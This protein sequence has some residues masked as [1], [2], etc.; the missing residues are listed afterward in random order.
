MHPLIYLPECAST[1]DEITTFLSDKS[2]DFKTLSLYTFHQ[3]QGRGQYGNVWKT[4]A[5]ENLAISIALKTSKIAIS[6]VL[7]NFHTA[8]VVR[9]FIANLTNQPTFVKWPNDIILNNKKISGMLIEKK[10]VNLQEYYIIGIGINVLQTQFENLPKAG[11]I[12]TQASMKLDLKD[13]TKKFHDFFVRSFFEAKNED[14]I[15]QEYENHLF[16]KEK[17]SVF[18]VKGIRQNGI[19]KKVDDEGFIWIDLENVGLRSFYHK[20]IEL[21]Y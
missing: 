19:I 4:I 15:L 5:N 1:N 9:E 20:E 18:E 6:N 3:K 21:L 17:V 14:Y 12:L 7:F 8:N 11:S 10:V 13:F 2:I 16:R